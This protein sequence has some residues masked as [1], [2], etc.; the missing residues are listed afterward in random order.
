MAG[1]HLDDGQFVLGLEAEQGER[2]ANMVV[3]VAFRVEQMVAT[4]Q[5][6]GYQF[7]GRGLAV[8]ASDADDACTQLAAVMAG[9]ALERQQA[10]V[11]QQVTVVARHEIFGF[12]D[13]G[14]GTS[15]FQ[16]LGGKGVAVKCVSLQGNEEGAFG[17]MTA[18]GRHTVTLVEY[19]VKSR[20]F[21]IFSV[22]VIDGYKGSL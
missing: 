18:V 2:H 19:L 21:H 6:G 4:A 13:D 17:A 15:A 3:Q 1:T 9:Q 5:Y 7:L 16:C 20:N 10:V 11:G 12:V 8:G 22:F 14:V